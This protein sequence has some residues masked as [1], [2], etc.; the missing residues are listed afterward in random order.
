MGHRHAINGQPSSVASAA[1]KTFNPATGSLTAARRANA[2][3]DAAVPL[4]LRLFPLVRPP[5]I[6]A[7]A[8]VKFLDRSTITSQAGH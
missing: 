1:S 3:S 5:P 8:S 7:P 4:V 6:A 2:R